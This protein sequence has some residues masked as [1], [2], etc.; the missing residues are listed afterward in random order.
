MSARPFFS[1]ADDE[2]R[3]LVLELVGL[4]VE[5]VEDSWRDGKR[6]TVHRGKLL[7]LVVANNAPT[8]L[9]VLAPPRGIRVARGFSLATVRSIQPVDERLRGSGS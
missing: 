7:P 6:T 2:R 9:I 8:A 4:E 1:L 3:A 5:V